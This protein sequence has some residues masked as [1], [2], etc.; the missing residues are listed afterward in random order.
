VSLNLIKESGSLSTEQTPARDDVIRVFEELC[1]CVPS[2]SAASLASCRSTF[3][4]SYQGTATQKGLK[5]NEKALLDMSFFQSL[6]KKF[7]LAIV[8]GR[9]RKVQRLIIPFFHGL[10]SKWV[11]GC[12]LV[13]SF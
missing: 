5:C 13:C 4:C 10:L 12:C 2:C 1:V 9:P 6:K 11:S 8:T 7:K 3:F